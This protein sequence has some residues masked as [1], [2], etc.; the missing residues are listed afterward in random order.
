MF[1]S[2][3]HNKK[4]TIFVK[5]VLFLS[6]GIILFLASVAI[7]SLHFAPK[8]TYIS[9]VSQISIT[10]RETTNA[11][12][13]A[14][15]TKLL[16]QKQIDYQAVVASGSSYLVTLKDGGQ[17]LLSPQKDIS[18]QISSLQFILSRLTMEGKLFSQLDLRFDKPIIVARE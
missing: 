6:G 3:R 14:N 13:L 17:V 7:F 16:G 18:V 8:P 1:R 11:D 12:N 4:R 9:P 5:Q 15:I 10:K 2:K